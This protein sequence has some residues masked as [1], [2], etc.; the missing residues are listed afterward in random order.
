MMYTCSSNWLVNILLNVSHE[1]ADNYS[2][3]P[4]SNTTWTDKT[5]FWPLQGH[6]Q[7][8]W[9]S[10]KPPSRL[11]QYVEAQF[12]ASVNTFT[13][14]Q[15]L[16]L[17]LCQY[18]CGISKPSFEPLSILS[19][20]IKTQFWDTTQTFSACW[21]TVL[22]ICQD[23]VKTHYCKSVKS[24]LAGWDPDLKPTQ[25]FLSMPKPSSEPLSRFF[26]W[27]KNHFET[28]ARLSL[29][30]KTYKACWNCSF[31]PLMILSVHAETQFENPVST[32]STWQTA[33]LNLW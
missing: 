8:F 12:W 6:S 25:Y 31:E 3:L 29:H 7:Q 20:C 15:K 9:S 19:R 23:I 21:S 17:S 14:C 32:F 16:V 27:V 10:F 13:A 24:F 4:L 5:M 18:F 26:H 1:L 22:N 28:D 2:I 30:I 11:S 33:V